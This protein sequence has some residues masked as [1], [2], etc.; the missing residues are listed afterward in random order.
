MIDSPCTDA[1]LAV[2]VEDVVL[3]VLLH[4][5]ATACFCVVSGSQPPSFG[6]L[7]P[8]DSLRLPL[9]DHKLALMSRVADLAVGLI[10]Q[11][12]IGGSTDT[13]VEN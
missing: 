1:L 6:G 12:S 5:L 3:P 2:I 10:S 13:A 7:L 4:Y 11:C 8:R 9:T